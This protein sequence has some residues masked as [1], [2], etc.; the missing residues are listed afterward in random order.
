MSLDHAILGF[1]QYGPLTGYDLKS[2]FDMSVKHFWAADQSRI[3]RTLSKLADEGWAE[4]EVVAQDD[5]PD[6]KV[7]S[8]TESGRAELH[9]WLT[10]PLPEKKDHVQPLVQIFFAGKLS[11]D[12]IL[13][14]LKRMSETSHRRSQQLDTLVGS[15][16][17]YDAETS[18]RDNFFFDLTLEYGRLM[19]KASADWYD[20]VITRFENGEYKTDEEAK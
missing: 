3:Y 18:A 11:D 4:I 12:E 5:R 9:K 19:T 8:I 16:C 2:V 7:Y 13:A 14:M 15:D 20:S 6:R 17:E 10:N 1:L